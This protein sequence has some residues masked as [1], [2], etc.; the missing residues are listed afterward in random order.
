MYAITGI[1]GQVGGAVARNL[2]AQGKQV[3]AIV[4]N[5]AKGQAWAERGC[6]V[7]F[8]EIND[9]DALTK[10]FEGAAGVFVLL[11]PVFDPTPGFPEAQGAIDSI[12]KALSTARPGRVVCLSTIGGHVKKTNLLNQLHV[13]ETVLGG[14]GLP[15][16]FL[17]AAWFME[18]SAWDVAPARASGVIPSFLQ[19]LDKPFPMIATEDIG[20]VA[21]DLLVAPSQ[22]PQVVEVEGP[23]RITPN[24][25]ADIFSKLLGNDTRMQVVPRDSWETLLRSQ[26]MKNPTPRMQ[27][28][29]GFNEGWIEF[30]GGEANSLKG[31]TPLEAVLRSMVQAKTEQ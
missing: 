25:I 29:D 1:T 6:E 18:N 13:M 30:E 7:A 17:R 9:T 31:A 12:R 16:S 8:A 28:L 15:I 19:P 14:L 2:L 20:R 11:P 23:K 4:R 10:A 26:G 21:A 24:E 3:R 22:P 5:A 27:M